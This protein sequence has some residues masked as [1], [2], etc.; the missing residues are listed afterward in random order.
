[1][2]ETIAERTRHLHR[3]IRP[4]RFGP[5]RS[6]RQ[7]ASMVMELNETWGS[8][9]SANKVNHINQRASFPGLLAR[10]IL[11]IQAFLSSVDARYPIATAVQ[12]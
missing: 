11:N 4:G 2:I 3:A 8:A 9:K 12:P 6:Q 5:G 7:T 1:M 10:H